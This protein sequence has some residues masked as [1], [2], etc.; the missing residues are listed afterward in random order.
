MKWCWTKEALSEYLNL[1]KLK[2]LQGLTRNVILVHVTQWTREALF[3]IGLAEHVLDL[4][5]KQRRSHNPPIV[6]QC[7]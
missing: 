4:H 3:Q 2:N 1:V 5:V 7:L 6:I